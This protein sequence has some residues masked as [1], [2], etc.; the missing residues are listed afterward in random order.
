VLINPLGKVLNEKNQPLAKL[1]GFDD[2]FIG[3]IEFAENGCFPSR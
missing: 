2:V 3:G 1:G